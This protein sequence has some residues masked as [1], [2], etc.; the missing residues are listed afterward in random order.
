MPDELQPVAGT[1]SAAVSTPS[2][3][4]R[5]Y[6]NDELRADPVVSSWAEKTDYKDI[7]AVLKGFAHA[8]KRMGSAIN[9]PGQGAKPEE[10]T[11]LR[12]KLYEA[13]VFTAPP[14]TA[15]EYNLVAPNEYTGPKMNQETAQQFAT[16]MHKHG[17]SQAAV[18]DLLPLYLESLGGQ[19]QITKADQESGMNELRKQFGEQFDTRFEMASRMLPGIFTDPKE[20]ALYEQLGLGNDARFLGPLMRLSA[21]AAQDSSFID[22]LPVSGGQITGESATDEYAKILNDPKHPQYEGFRR[23]D[24]KA[25]AYVDALYRRA[26]GNKQVQLDAG[27]VSV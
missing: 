10:V 22:S 8:Q 7:P 18:N 19:Q 3:D 5:P 4:W 24:P 17:I 12:Q 27:G 2:S 23:N 11:A 14:K 25:I 16:M 26:Y 21:L 20:M 9:L 6:L 15:G 1:G 13:G